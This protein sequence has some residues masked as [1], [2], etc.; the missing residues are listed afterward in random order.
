M[1]ILGSGIDI[2]EIDRVSSAISRTP[3]FVY[4]VFT[5]VER[6]YFETKK[7]NI[8]TIAGCFAA[9]EAVAKAL[10]TGF[11]G[12]KPWNIEICWDEFGKPTTKIE[13]ATCLISISHSKNYAVASALLLEE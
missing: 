2:I 11:A 7:N 1:K 3:R 10:G 12:I 5:E 4:R 6:R 9:K 13:G 8:A